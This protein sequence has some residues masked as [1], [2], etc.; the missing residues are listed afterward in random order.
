MQPEKLYHIYNHANGTEN[1]FREVE[2]YRYFLRQW[3]KHIQPIADSLAYCLMPNHFHF[4]VKIRDES[5]LEA[6]I[7]SKSIERKSLGGFQTLQGFKKQEAIEKYVSLQFSHLF[8]GYTQAFNK[9]YQRKGSLFNPNFRKKEINSSAYISRVIA[10][11]H[12]NPV[13]HGFTKNLE[14]W[15]FCSYNA[16]LSNKVTLLNVEYVL[17]WFGGKEE[18]I[19]FHQSYP[20]QANYLEDS[21]KLEL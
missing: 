18:F 11:I 14:E 19:K 13:L 17:D 9:K 2:N 20:E 7:N 15:P 3:E 6:I 8:N 4:L 16:Y 12:T 5:E 1:L 10:Y 21:Q